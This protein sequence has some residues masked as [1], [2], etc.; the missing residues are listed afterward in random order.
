MKMN[1]TKGSARARLLT[2]TLLAGLATVAAPLAVTAIAT[3]IP[4]LASAQDY[5]SGTLTGSVTDSAG[6]PVDGAAVTVKSLD[7]GFSRTLTT[8]ANGQFR[9]PL[10]PGGG[11]SVA[12]S[13]SGFA[14]TNDGNVR[15]NAGGNS[16]YTFTLNS[17]DAS[18]SEVVVTATANPQ[19]DFSQSTKGLSIDVET[20]QKQVPLPRN[21]QGIALLAPGVVGAVSGPNG[22]TNT[23]G[24]SVPSIG[25]GSAGE[26]SFYING[27]NV[28]N[29]N[30][31]V[32]GATVP[33]DFYK[34]VDVKTGG[35]PAEF[36]RATGGVINAVTK[37]GTNDFKVVVHGNFQFKGLQDDSPSTYL[38][39]GNRNSTDSKQYTLEV[40]GPII[41]DRL[42]AYAL[43][44][45]NDQVQTTGS[46][47]N[48]AYYVDRSSDPFYGIKLDGYLTDRQ[49]FEYTQFSTAQTVT[50][51]T[52]GYDG[53]ADTIGSELVGTKYKNGGINYVAKYTGTFTDWFTLSAAYGKNKDE[54]YTLPAVSGASFVQDA[55]GPG[56]T[57]APQ[58][59]NFAIG[60]TPAANAT[61]DFANTD[62]T[63][64]RIDGDLY[65]K[66]MGDHHIRGGYDHEK[67]SLFHASTRSGGAQYVYRIVNTASQSAST[68]LPIGQQYVRAR[69]GN[70]GG[71]TVKGEN[72]SFYLQDSWDLTERLNLQIGVRDDIF[73]L[74]NLRG[75]RVLNL[76][77]NWAPRLAASYDLT[78][79]GQSKVFAS[80][81]RYYIPPAS[82][83]SFRGAD[84]YY[85][86]YFLPPAGLS[87]NPYMDPVLKTPTLGA[88]IDNPTFDAGI[89]GTTCPVG[90]PLIKS[91]G[92]CAVYGNGTQEPAASKP[93]IG[94]KA[95][96]EDEFIIGYERKLDALWKIGATL[97]YRNL[98]RVSEDIAMDSAILKYCARNPSTNGCGAADIE[99]VFYGDADYVVA[100]PGKDT[101]IIVRTDLANPLAGQKITL[102]G[103]D[104]GNPKAKREYTA[105]ELSFSRAFD[106][107]WSLNGSYTLSRLAGNYEGTVK[108]DSG[109]LAQSDAGSTSDFD[110]PGLSEFA[111]GLLPN[112][113]AHQ[114]KLYGAYAITDNLQVGANLQVASPRHYSCLG[115]YPGNGL[116]PAAAGY[117]A[118]SHYCYD[119]SSGTSKPAPRGS[120]FTGDWYSNVD[121]QVRYTVPEMAY[122]PKG[123]T[124]RADVFNLFNQDN[125]TQFSE[126]GDASAGVVDQH[127]GDVTQYQPPRTVRL[128]FDLSF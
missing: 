94:L 123:L 23:D 90:A 3:A 39:N 18:V 6:A 32:G 121:L 107:K 125:A 116:D 17:A 11:Y 25:G 47:L 97:T 58:G 80:Y 29:F 4:T 70:F 35:Y 26:N 1:A 46:I 22:F 124:L 52:Y 12:I 86:A 74:D 40:G 24:S 48:S 61:S 100:N 56:F 21:I 81:G 41:K 105:L 8:D 51:R 91:A 33:F 128:G 102:S 20:L 30:T 64:Y 43:Y 78:G 65:F 19:L 84:L 83:L 27:L 77:S 49:H 104:I 59:T 53:A 34:S 111:Y 60:T 37:S 117:G 85:D 42:F 5:T 62:R 57:P 16:G 82:N 10:I 120:A 88:Q 69:V 118:I 99:D 98:G 114:F 101:T 14:S 54:D 73:R 36:G 71:S 119:T 96:Y 7:Q 68:G 110:H 122:L 45:T 113:R 72:E 93:A 31:Y 44:Q 13:K 28:T 106:G 92:G 95:S 76:K 115:V 67:T 127:F 109:N 66:L 89:G 108:S 63:F 2:S 9:V 103:D 50:R 38:E 15:V 79:D 112:H 87:F 75:E 126:V 55:R